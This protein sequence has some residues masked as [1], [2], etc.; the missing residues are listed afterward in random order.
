MKQQ[1]ENCEGRCYGP[2]GSSTQALLT[3]RRQ[4]KISS[5]GLVNMQ[6]DILTD[7]LFNR[8]VKCVFVCV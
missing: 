3:E 5:L 8:C 4:R 7:I 2:H 1:E 6:V